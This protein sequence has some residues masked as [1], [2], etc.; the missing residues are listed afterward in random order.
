MSNGEMKKRDILFVICAILNKI[1]FQGCSARF[2]LFFFFFSLYCQPLFFLAA[3]DFSFYLLN[4]R[5]VF[6]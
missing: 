3:A 6:L 4:F 2:L 5:N 1:I